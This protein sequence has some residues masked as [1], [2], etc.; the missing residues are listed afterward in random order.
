VAAAPVEHPA[1]SCTG[2]A[3]RT[4]CR[5]PTTR[6]R[7]RRLARARRLPQGRACRLP[8][9]AAGYGHEVRRL[10][11]KLFYR[12]LLG[13]SPGC[14]P[15]RPGSPRPRRRPAWRRSASP[16]RRRPAPPGGAHQRG[17]APGG[18]PAD[19]ACRP[20]S[21]GSPTPPTPTRAQV[22]P[23][24][25]GRPRRHALVP[26]LLR[27]EGQA[28]ERLA[29]LLRSS[30]FVADLLGRAPEAVRLLA[31]DDELRPPA[32]RGA[33]ARLRAGRPAPR[34]LGGHGRRRARHAPRGAAAG[35][36]R[37]RPRLLDL[38]AV[39]GALSD[40]A[41]AVLAAALETATRKVEAERRTALPVTMAVLAMG[42][43]G[44]REQGYGSDAD[45]TCSGTRRTRGVPDGVA[46]SAAHGRPHELR[47]LARTCPPP[48]RRS[49]STPTPA[50]RERQGPLSPLP[51]LLPGVLRPGRTCG[52]AGPLRAAPLVA[53][54]GWPHPRPGRVRRSL[55]RGRLDRAPGPGVRPDQGAHGGPSACRGA[56]TPS[57]S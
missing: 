57:S 17:V 21:A 48:T 19:A 3:A 4:C 46:A 47:R 12:P 9:R 20:C 1:C 35:R 18:H 44:G 14:P 8:P 39:G 6:S 37:R 34:G 45:V 51:A 15:S 31:S 41:A 16:S 11:E 23:V 28:A 22:V 10:H 30:R 49:S 36:L 13:A 24:G 27:D 52:G 55:P 32:A 40:V 33:G 7:L 42:R 54:P 50:E 5:P 25:L 56:S 38:A 29:H 53:T 26:A 2:C 43:L